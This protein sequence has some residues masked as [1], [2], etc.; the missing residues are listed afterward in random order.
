MTPVGERLRRERVRL[1]VSLAQLAKD[2]RINQNYL[3][4][5][6]AGDPSRIPGGFFYRSFI[7]QYAQ[8][9]NVE[10]P[11]LEAELERAREAEVPVLNAAL[12]V[13]QFPL[14]EQDPIVVAANRK[15]ARGR[16][17]GAVLMLIAVV[18]GCSAFNSWWHRVETA[19]ARVV[20]FDSE[21]AAPATA[22][23]VVVTPVSS[24]LSPD[25]VAPTLEAAPGPEDKVVLAVSAHEKTWITI[26]SDGKTMFSGVLEPSQTKVLGGKLRAYIRVGNA[27]GLEIT[28][29]GKAIG[30]IGARGQV[31]S[32]L[33][34]PENYQIL[35]QA[36][37]SL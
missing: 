18:A 36:G 24:P 29:N 15:L 35:P 28:W 37:G 31:K 2:T 21:P 25:A 14:K 22:E 30:P 23:S 26:T 13:A 19:P 10:V 9:L 12:K 6:E 17:G 3:E 16:I 5:I 1:G 4:A 8:H 33:F 32:V 7:R 11:D 20:A 34:T 27:A